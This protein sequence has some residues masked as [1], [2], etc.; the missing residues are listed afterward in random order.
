MI[1]LIGAAEAVS[2]DLRVDQSASIRSAL[3]KA[4]YGGTK[5]T[6]AETK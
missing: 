4:V 3:S 2:T 5:V 6:R 1:V